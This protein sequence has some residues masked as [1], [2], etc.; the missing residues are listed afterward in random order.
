MEEGFEALL[1]RLR[2]GD[3]EAAQE[4]AQALGDRG[5]PRA[6][7]A[8]MEA[9]RVTRDR[10]VRNRAA[11]ALAD[12][13][14]HE[15]VPLLLRVA[16]G[17]L[18]GGDPGTLIYALESLNCRDHFKDVA[19]FLWHGDPECV[20]SAANILQ[21]IDFALDPAKRTELCDLLASRLKDSSPLAE[22]H[23]EAI[24]EVLRCLET[25]P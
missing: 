13:K 24:E 1:S 10:G 8:L 23:K 18:D 3:E 22:F 21:D 5:D 19:F 7:P 16:W 25:N 15:A 4:A 11:L 20:A 17:Q 12:L 6:I 14:A 9:L 2:G